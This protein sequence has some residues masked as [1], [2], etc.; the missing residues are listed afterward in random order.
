MRISDWSSDVCSSDLC[1]NCRVMHQTLF[2]NATVKQLLNRD[3][4]LVRVDYDAPEAEAFMARYQVRY[5]PS[6]VVLGGDGVL[7]RR[8]PVPQTAAEF[9]DVWR[10][11]R[12]S[13]V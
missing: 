12:K 5:F 9:V 13:V 4:V 7:Q 2:T 1:G 10:A 11:D 3:Y 8:L 6:L